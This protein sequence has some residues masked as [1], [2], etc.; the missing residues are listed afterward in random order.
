MLIRTW[1]GICNFG[2]QEVPSARRW[3][4]RCAFPCINSVHTLER[5]LD[6]CIGLFLS[7]ENVGESNPL[8]ICGRSTVVRSCILP[9]RIAIRSPRVNRAIDDVSNRSSISLGTTKLPGTGAHVFRW[10]F[11]TVD[12]F[13]SHSDSCDW[14][15]K[16][17]GSPEIFIVAGTEGDRHTYFHTCSLSQLSAL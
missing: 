10:L 11:Q 8:L 17:V 4:P 12:G 16:Q 15:G 2:S 13:A 9:T 14:L 5:A 3:V 1:M 7:I 6:E